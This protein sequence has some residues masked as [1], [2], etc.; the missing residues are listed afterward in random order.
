LLLLRPAQLSLNGRELDNYPSL[1]P[2]DPE[3]KGHLSTPVLRL[4]FAFLRRFNQ[5]VRSLLGLLDL[6]QARSDP[7]STAAALTRAKHFLFRS[8]KVCEPRACCLPLR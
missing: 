5:L 7:W 2:I 6:R 4:R 3:A 1:K 8:V